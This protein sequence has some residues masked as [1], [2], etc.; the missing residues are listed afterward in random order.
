MSEPSSIRAEVDRS[1]CMGYAACVAIAPAAFR[2]D[3]TGI[4]VPTD[5]PSDPALLARAIDD[6]PRSAIRL[7]DPPAPDARG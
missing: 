6:C 7:V 1:L 3:A 2:L 4:S 5:A